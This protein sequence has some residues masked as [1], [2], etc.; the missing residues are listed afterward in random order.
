MARNG[1]GVPVFVM[2]PLDSVELVKSESGQWM[3]SLCLKRLK[4][5][6]VEGV[7]MDVWWGLVEKTAPRVYDWSLYDKLVKVIQ[8]ND[9]KLQAV[10][11]FHQCGGNV[12]DGVYIPLPDW[13]LE[14]S[15]RN[16]DIFYTD[17]SGWRNP[18][19]ISL[20]CDT[21]PVIRG[22]TPVQCYS[23]Y[24]TSFRDNYKS[25][26]GDVI[27][28]I[29]VGMG[30][31]GELRYPSYPQSENQ[32]TFPGIGEL[33]C[34]DK[35]MV[36]SLQA[37]ATSIGKPQYGKIPT[38]AGTYNQLPQDTG[39]WRDNGTWKTAYGQFFLSWYS[40]QILSHGER[41]LTVA[42]RVFKNKGVVLSAKISGIHWH[43]KTA[44]H[45]A[46]CGVG[47]YNTEK[48]NGYLP[49][50]RMFAKYNTVFNFTCLEM[51][52]FQQDAVA[53]S[54]P[55]SLIR[56]VA[57]TCSKADIRMSGENALPVFDDAS[58]DQISETASLQFGGDN[59]GGDTIVSFTYLRLSEDLF[60]AENWSNFE[61]FVSKMSEVSA[62]R[63]NQVGFRSKL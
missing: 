62:G 23:D 59:V 30:P 31:A 54:S 4:D 22:R 50:A 46:E 35:Y 11:S 17:Q 38:D 13:V 28:E 43:Y 34:Y 37:K 42:N 55:E 25:V 33:Q 41:V 49:I 19:Y 32:W 61:E 3:L 40:E 51:K 18:E 47:Y 15:H 26:L 1:S 29:Q 14:E 63:A 27:I 10:M 36:T 16:P 60:N 53:N 2:M 8:D 20:G 58:Y 48:R 52:D 12:G 45:A 56:Q 24:M 44:S 21:L 6:G 9:L 5:A 39:F 57:A 7:M